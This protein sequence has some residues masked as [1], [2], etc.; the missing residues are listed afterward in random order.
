MLP[1][2]VDQGIG[3]IPWSP[4]AKGFLMGNRTKD[5]KG[6]T[7]RSTTDG[8]AHG[9]YYREIDFAIAD[10]VGELAGR[11]GV[12]RAQVALA[13]LLH[14]P[15]VT[16]PIIGATKTQHIEDNVGALAVKLGKEDIAFLE[17][18]YQPRRVLNM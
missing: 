5:K 14:K 12:T 13:W 17:E 8:I 9:L 4:L 7:T 11:L 3:V 1:L 16:S 6:E 15:G 2:C 10:R 18:P